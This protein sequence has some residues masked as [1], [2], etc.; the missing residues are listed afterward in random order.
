MSVSEEDRGET[1][2]ANREERLTISRRTFLKGSAYVPPALLTLMVAR[3]AAYAATCNPDR[4]GP[5]SCGPGCPP[6]VGC[7]PRP[8]N[9]EGGPGNP[10]RRDQ[11]SSPDQTPGP[12]DNAVPPEEPANVP[13]PSR[14][15]PDRDYEACGPDFQ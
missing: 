15:S 13:N 9:P 1:S 11:E 8:C 6:K 3:E 2:R 14:R 5:A 4:C 7:N 12:D 10:D